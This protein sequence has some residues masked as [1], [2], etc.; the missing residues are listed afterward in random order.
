MINKLVWSNGINRHKWV[1]DSRSDIKLH[2]HSLTGIKKTSKNN[3]QIY[4]SVCY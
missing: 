1:K 3:K 4:E 2:N